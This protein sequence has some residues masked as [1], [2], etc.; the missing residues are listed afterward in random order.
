MA[1]A[2]R[3]TILSIVGGRI[4]RRIR[5]GLFDAVLRQDTALFD[6][7]KSGEL[8][9]R[10]RSDVSVVG[11]TLTDNSAKLLRKSIT[12]AKS[13]C[14][15]AF[16]SPKLTAVDLGFVPAKFLFGVIFDRT[17]RRLSHDLI[18]ALAAATQVA[19]ERIGSIRTVRLFGAEAFESARYARRVDET[20][21][22]GQRVA[23][24]DG[25]FTG[26]MF[27]AAQMSLLG[28]LY[29][30]GGMVLD[31]ANVLYVGIL[32][33]FSIYAVNLGISASSIGSAYGQ[34]LRV[35]HFDFEACLR[36][37]VFQFTRRSA[38][39]RE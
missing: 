28:V 15:V 23:L 36:V 17:Q 34:V 20:Y 22:L 25:V 31:A 13:L 16:L 26:G 19:S 24:A 3:V 8:F 29:L 30:G 37:R 39:Y 6:K 1:T 14:M 11:R 7:N 4:S 35:E 9:K 32:T 21:G 27:Y 10:L 18:D 33:S 2:T 12:G 38:L 5:K